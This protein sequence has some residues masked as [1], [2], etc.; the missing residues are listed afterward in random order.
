MPVNNKPM[1]N[2][3]QFQTPAKARTEY[4]SLFI[5]VSTRERLENIFEEDR[6][7]LGHFEV[8]VP[9]HLP[10]NIAAATAMGAYH[11]TV[12]IKYL[13]C[14]EYTIRDGRGREVAPDYDA[15]WY[16]LAEEHKAFLVD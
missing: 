10:S 15:D 2:L 9:S 16:E 8:A 12:P 1:T 4:T 14:F 5:E 11:N 3:S 13:G 7:A 6:D